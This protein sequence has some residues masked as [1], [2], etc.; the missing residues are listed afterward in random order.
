MKMVDGSLYIETELPY[1]YI[2]LIMVALGT[3]LWGYGD[4]PFK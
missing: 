3:V 1:R 2:S 4:I